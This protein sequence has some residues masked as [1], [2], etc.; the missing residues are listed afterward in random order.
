MAHGFEVLEMLCG[1]T[2][3]TIYG[4]EYENIVWG[5][6]KPIT[7]KQ[8]TDGFAAVDAWKAQQEATKS[9]EKTALLTK[10]GIT[11]DEAKLLLS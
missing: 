2:G 11:S 4:D 7:K 10:L 6:C 1:Q 8:F 3:W 5:E 9:A